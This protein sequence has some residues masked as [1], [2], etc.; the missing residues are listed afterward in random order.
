A[1]SSD[2]LLLKV[3]LTQRTGKATHL[4]DPKPPKCMRSTDVLHRE[5]TLGSMRGAPQYFLRNGRLPEM[6][7]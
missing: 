7:G 4:H 6:S 1:S 2:W 3:K 5:R